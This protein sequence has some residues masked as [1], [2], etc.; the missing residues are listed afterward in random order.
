MFFPRAFIENVMIGGINKRIENHVTLGEFL[1]WLG[2][3]LLLATMNGFSRVE[4]WS[5]K[6]I[7]RRNGAPYRFND[8]MSGRRFSEI[9]T[10]LCYT[11][12]QA[13]SFCDRFWEVR[14]IVQE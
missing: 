6:P 14:Q 12:R 11:D 13:P 1:R 8:L 4:F 5:E 7:D 2:I 9:L 10:N 3:W